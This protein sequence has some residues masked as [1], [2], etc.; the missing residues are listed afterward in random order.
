MADDGC[1]DNDPSVLRSSALYIE[2]GAI[3]DSRLVT[4]THTSLLEEKRENRVIA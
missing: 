3:E 4:M 2:A 1:A